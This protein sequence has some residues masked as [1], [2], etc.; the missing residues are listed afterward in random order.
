MPVLG[1]SWSSSWD[2]PISIGIRMQPSSYFMLLILKR[3]MF[4]EE[5]VALLCW[6]ST[7]LSNRIMC[8]SFAILARLVMATCLLPNAWDQCYSIHLSV[9]SCLIPQIPIHQE[10]LKHFISLKLDQ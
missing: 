1:L 5:E 6:H 9:L 2:W 7:S 8:H 4:R 3:R 10:P